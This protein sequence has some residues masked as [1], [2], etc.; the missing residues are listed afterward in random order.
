MEILLIN[1][2]FSRL[3][4]FNWP[5]FERAYIRKRQGGGGLIFGML[6]GLYTW[7]HIFVYSGGLIYGELY[8][9]DFTVF[10]KI[11]RLKYNFVNLQENACRYF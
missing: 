7:G 11:A 6:I 1:L 4:K 10:Q 9:Q 8:K 3:D 2:M 5:I